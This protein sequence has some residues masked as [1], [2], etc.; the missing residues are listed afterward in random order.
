[1]S[2]RRILAAAFVAVSALV[3]T[4]ASAVTSC[5]GQGHINAC[6]NGNNIYPCCDNGGNCTWWAWEQ[7]CRNWHVSL[8]NWGNANTWAAHAN[9][10]PNYDIVGY[11]VVDSIAT[12]TLG[13]FGHVAWVTGGGGGG[14][15]VTEENCCSGCK[16]GV[17]AIAYPVSKF[18]SGFVVRHGS[19]CECTS[20]QTATETCSCGTRSRGCGTDCKWSGWGACAGT[21][22]ICDGID[23]DCNGAIDDGDPAELAAKPPALA[24]QLVD[25]SYPQSAHEGERALAWAEFKN[26]GTQ[27]WTKNGVWLGA[28]AS[29][30][31]ASAYF[32]SATWPAWN[33]AA[34]LDRDVAPGET[35]RFTFQIRVAGASG[36][37][38]AQDFRLRLPDEQTMKCP[39]SNVAART[40]VVPPQGDGG[41]G[42]SEPSVDGCSYAPSRPAPSA[43][44]LALAALALA[45]L[46]RRARKS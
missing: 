27:T 25:V 29:D 16:A 43:G 32:D 33:V 6:G 4:P 23:N 15:S 3:A 24:A 5:G 30:S 1:M 41:V 34:V 26:V 35:A 39:S 22:E 9:L 36:T 38:I 18:N 46:R 7:V 12:S 20:G 21:K 17:R 31:V 44:A 14:V 13:N 45:A 10:D 8:V 28:N 11:P 19:L 37:Q 40:W 42:S 2:A